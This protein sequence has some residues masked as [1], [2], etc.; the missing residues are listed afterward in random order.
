MTQHT[1]VS[2][3]IDEDTKACADAVLS[4]IGLTIADA[5]RPIHYPEAADAP[6]RLWAFGE[7]NRQQ[8][9]ATSQTALQASLITL[10]NSQGKA[11]P[12]ILHT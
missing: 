10:A 11:F 7:L 4:A 5:M 8:R 6:A 2:V 12:I 9:H 3:R 1:L